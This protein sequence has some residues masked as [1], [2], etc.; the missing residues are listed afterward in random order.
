[1]IASDGTMNIAWRSTKKKLLRPIRSATAGDAAK[2]SIRPM[3]ISAMNA[4]RKKRSM[5]Q[6]HSATGPRSTRLTMAS[7][8]FSRVNEHRHAIE[9]RNLRD[10]RITSDFKVLILIEACASRG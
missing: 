8:P 1:M 3:P 10:E 2:D 6:N 7:A 4:A 5:V 9:R